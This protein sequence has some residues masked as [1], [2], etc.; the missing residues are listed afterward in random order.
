MLGSASTKPPT[1]GGFSEYLLVGAEQCFPVPPQIDDGLGAMIEPFAVALH[2]LKRVGSVVG[3]PVPAL[4]QAFEVVRRG[5]TIVQIGVY[6]A[7][8]ISLPVNQLCRMYLN[9]SGQ[10]SVGYPFP[11][12]TYRGSGIAVDKYGRVWVAFAHWQSSQPIRVYC[13]DANLSYMTEIDPKLSESYADLDFKSGSLLYVRSQ[14]RLKV[15]DIEDRT[16]LPIDMGIDPEGQFENG[17]DAVEDGYT[18]VLANT[19]YPDNIHR[20]ITRYLDCIS[21]DSRSAPVHATF[22]TIPTAEITWPTNGLALERASATPLVVTGSAFGPQFSRYVLEA[23][24]GLVPT[25]WTVIASATT[26]VTNGSLGVWCLDGLPTG[27]NT[28]RLQAFD[29]LGNVGE[30]SVTVLV[31]APNLALRT[32]ALGPNG[33]TIT[34]DAVTIHLSAIDDSTPAEQIEYSWNLNDQ[35][36]SAFTTSPTVNLTGIG[37]G[38]NVFRVRARDSAGFADPSPAVISFVGTVEHNPETAINLY[39]FS[40]Q[41]N[42][43]LPTTLIAS[44]FSDTDPASA[45]SRSQFEVRADPGSFTSPLWDSGETSPATSVAP[46]PVGTLAEATK[47]WWHARHRDDTGRWSAWSGETGFTTGEAPPRLDV[48]VAANKILLGWDTNKV[49]FALEYTT[50]LT[51]G[52]LW[53]PVTEIPVI[54]NAQNIVTNDVSGPQ[55][56]YRLKKL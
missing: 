44:A 16:W 1:N 53:A 14:Y 41:T 37:S 9:G 20:N 49:G 45:F 40:G 46:I 54:V 32:Y 33:E 29:T 18:Y 27:A 6:S 52:S 21:T 15:Y 26:T 4:R 23:S 7:P 43:P 35:G 56:F 28:I 10:T 39:P 55:R 8:E 42:V 19:T 30:S 51:A 47:Y 50:N 22:S 48:F 25:N 34:N 36:W 31:V 38:T 3:K 5:G 13:Y 2:A 24:A 11:D 12:K 17:I